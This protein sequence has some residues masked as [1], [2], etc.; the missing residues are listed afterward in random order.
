MTKTAIPGKQTT[1]RTDDVIQSEAM[2]NPKGRQ[3]TRHGKN[4]SKRRT[5]STDRR[6]KSAGLS[7]WKEPDEAFFVIVL[8]TL[9][10]CILCKCA[11]S[12]PP[13]NPWSS[14]RMK[15]SICKM[16]HLPFALAFCIKVAHVCIYSHTP[17]SISGS[18]RSS[19]ILP[20]L[21]ASWMT[22]GV[23]NQ[24]SPEK[25]GVPCILDRHWVKR[26]DGSHWILVF[27]AC[28]LLA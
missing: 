27:Y 26:L 19:N 14:F 7:W 4:C 20:R 11:I 8:A 24:N 6:M 22:L 21:L 9:A 10:L 5:M 23:D 28:V 17:S 1:A 16:G 18:K 25:E 15:L 13:P 12:S 2:S 3:R